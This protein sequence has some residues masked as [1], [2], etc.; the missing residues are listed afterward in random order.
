MVHDTPSAT[1]V[2][3]YNHPFFQNLR[4]LQVGMPAIEQMSGQVQDDIRRVIDMTRSP[5]F[6]LM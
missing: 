1:G 2:D 6:T 3:V 4:T 5:T